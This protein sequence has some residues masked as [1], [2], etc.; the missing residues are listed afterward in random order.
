MSLVSL[1]FEEK[2]GNT[3]VKSQILDPDYL[4]LYDLTNSLACLGG[5]KDDADVCV[6]YT[7]H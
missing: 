4:R 6:R 5:Y 1:V 3:G 7:S 2:D